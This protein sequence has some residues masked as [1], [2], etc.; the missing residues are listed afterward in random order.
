MN[1][2]IDSKGMSMKKNVGNGHLVGC[3][4]NLLTISNLSFLMS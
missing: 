2:R 1:S 4:V 3:T